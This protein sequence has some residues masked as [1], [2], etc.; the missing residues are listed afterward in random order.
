LKPNVP[1]VKIKKPEI[2][3]VRNISFSGGIL[4]QTPQE[5]FSENPITLSDVATIASG[6]FQ[7]NA[8]SMIGGTVVEGIPEAPENRKV[9]ARRNASWVELKTF[10]IDICVDG[11]VK[12]LDVYVA[13]PSY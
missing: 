6:I 13:G 7:S 12:K 2:A 1:K 9:Y 11:V 4:T 10:T 3:N 5:V 8:P